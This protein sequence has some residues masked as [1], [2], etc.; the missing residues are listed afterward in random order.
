MLSK[1]LASIFSQL[2]GTQPLPALKAARTHPTPIIDSR[3]LNSQE[4]SDVTFVVENKPF[5][6]HKIILVSASPR[7][8][9]MLSAIGDNAMPEIEI[10]D[11]DFQTF[12]VSQYK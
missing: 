11:I 4:L 12:E 5:Y 10:S 6:A 8:K 9:S 3:Y 2:Y 7:F 1:Q